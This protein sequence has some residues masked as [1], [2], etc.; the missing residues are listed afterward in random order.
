[1]G[2]CALIA[3][4]WIYDGSVL[5]AR[6]QTATSTAL[7]ATTTHEVIAEAAPPFT[8]QLF[9]AQ[10]ELSQDSLAL[11][12]RVTTTPGV[13]LVLLK[14]TSTPLTVEIRQLLPEE[15]PLEAWNATTTT[16]TVWQIDVTSPVIKPWI[17]TSPLTITFPTSGPYYKKKII[18]FW[19]N[20]RVQW[21]DLP[22]TTDFDD[23]TVSAPYPLPFGRFIVR[24]SET[25]YEGIASWYKWKGCNCAAFRFLPKKTILKVTNISGSARTG[26]SVKVRINDYGPE[27][28]TERIIDLDYVAYK[29]I[30]LTRGGVMPV[31]VE[32]IQ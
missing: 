8:P 3:V 22:S 11:G 6:A 19:D 5:E 25:I 9:T 17:P 12:A 2:A 10:F 14:T 23:H 20:L 21:R 4:A 18:S 15:L 27:E 32:V 7:I 30:G 31:R 28:W 26:K 29:K 16:T 13:E 1:M 24:E